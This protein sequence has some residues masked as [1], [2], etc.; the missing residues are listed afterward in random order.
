MS[1]LGWTLFDEFSDFYGLI[2][3]SKL[4]VFGIPSWAQV[5]HIAYLTY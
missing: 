1:V 3:E 4:K 5:P 2:L